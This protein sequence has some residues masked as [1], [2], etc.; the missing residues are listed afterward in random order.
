MFSKVHMLH[1][2]TQA[3]VARLSEDL[4]WEE[5]RPPTVPPLRV[6]SKRQG[7][8]SHPQGADTVSVVMCVGE[9]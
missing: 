9:S 4:P 5:G 6:E 8:D 7:G 2:K 3:E 1:S